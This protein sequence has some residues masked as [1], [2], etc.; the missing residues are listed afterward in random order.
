MSAAD[1]AHPASAAPSATI[2]KFRINAAPRPILKAPSNLNQRARS[3]VRSSDWQEYRDGSL[4]L[5]SQFSCPSGVENRGDVKPCTPFHESVYGRPV[6]FIP[7][8]RVLSRE[9]AGLLQRSHSPPGR[10]VTD[11]PVH[12]DL[13]VGQ[14]VGI[15]WCFVGHAGRLTQRGPLGESGP[16]RVPTIH[17]PEARRGAPEGDRQ[18]SPNHGGMSVGLETRTRAIAAHPWSG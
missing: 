10:L 11:A 14:E 13:S 5:Q 17:R 8:K 7:E 3:I 6:A 18:D 2:P 9:S 15:L 12:R 4:L 16:A 1:D